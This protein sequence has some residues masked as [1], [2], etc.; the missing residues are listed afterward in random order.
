MPKIRAG[1]EAVPASYQGREVLVLRD[2]TGISADLAVDRSSA[3]ILALMDGSSSLR[4]IQ[5]VL[6]RQRGLGLVSLDEIQT[7]VETLD[8]HFLL[9]NERYRNHLL[10]VS[11]RFRQERLRPASHAG[12]AYAE[13]PETL[14]R[15]LEGYF[16]PPNGPGH[17]N[18]D[19]ASACSMGLVVPHIDFDRGGRCY[20]WGYAALQDID[21]VELFV[22][23]G[24]C[25]LP[26]EQP[27]A[28]TTKVF[29]TPLGRTPSD[30]E[31][32]EAIVQRS[33]QDLFQDEI[34]HRA[35][36]TIEF[37]LIFLQY[38]LGDERPL[39][40]L[41][42]LCGGFHEM[43]AQRILPPSHPPYRQGLEAIREVLSDSS[44][45]I[46]VIAS[47]DL[48][49]LG[50]QF[51]DPYPVSTGDLP[52]IEREDRAMLEPVLEGDADRFYRF[53]LGEGDRRRICGLPP[54][55]TLLQ[56][57]R[58][59]EIRLLKYDQAHHPQATVTFASA[60]FWERPAV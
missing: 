13:D 4:D 59:G 30:A 36:H 20:A 23:L 26:M 46:C 54:I 1:V 32:A 45:R 42:V 53:I 14:R 44:R 21:R 10:D 56:M 3:S 24:T 7:F 27:F 34:A 48:S 9:D 57:I 37:Q 35:E 51:G 58:P 41:P 5:V 29:E 31:L 2:R 43:M 50:P 55:Y 15:Q 17:P 6:M 25:H 16:Q 60:G 11:N 28:L 12:S 8:S 38:L 49:H 40:V 22:I 39:R 52:R 18:H 19:R 33:G 47:A